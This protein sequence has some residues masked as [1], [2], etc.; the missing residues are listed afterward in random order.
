MICIKNS[1]GHNSIKNV[2]AV[3]CVFSAHYLM[4]VYI[5]AKFHQNILI[6]KL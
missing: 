5:S 4:V 1:K 3:M 6:S 2:G